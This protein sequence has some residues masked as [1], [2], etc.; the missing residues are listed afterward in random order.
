MTHHFGLRS[1]CVVKRGEA[2][3]KSGLQAVREFLAR[4]TECLFRGQ[5]RRFAPL[6][7]ASGLPQSTDIARSARLV[8][9]VPE[10]D[11][12]IAR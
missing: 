10:T 7:A 6:P 11:I 12:V 1:G 8:R 2:R 3:A 9:S 4:V 5:T